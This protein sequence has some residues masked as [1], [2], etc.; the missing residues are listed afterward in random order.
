MEIIVALWWRFR[1]S[2]LKEA[3]GAA[4]AM[5]LERR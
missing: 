1:Y 4:E 3:A 2:D 5:G